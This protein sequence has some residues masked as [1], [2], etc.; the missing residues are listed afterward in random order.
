MCMCVCACVRA[1][2]RACVCAC[3]CVYMISWTEL[4]RNRMNI[5]YKASVDVTFGHFPQ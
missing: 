3:V 4:R 5:M 2:V 1:C